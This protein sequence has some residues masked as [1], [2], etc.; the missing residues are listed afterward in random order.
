[1]DE[2]GCRVGDH[3]MVKPDARLRTGIAQVVECFCNGVPTA[4]IVE[5]PACPA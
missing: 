1:M 2:S 4:R 5:C 3:L